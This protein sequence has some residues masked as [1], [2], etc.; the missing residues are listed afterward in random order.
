MSYILK[1]ASIDLEELS[2]EHFIAEHPWF[3]VL[4][5]HKS[6]FFPELLNARNQTLHLQNT[7]IFKCFKHAHT[8]V[9]TSVTSGI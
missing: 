6:N 2:D 3:I 4:P 5:V 7:F 9:H 1:Q 8:G